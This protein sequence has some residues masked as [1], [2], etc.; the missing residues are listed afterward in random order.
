MIKT[1][2]AKFRRQNRP[3]NTLLPTWAAFLSQKHLILHDLYWEAL[4]L[5]DNFHIDTANANINI[6]PICVYI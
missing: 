3:N 6:G 2:C 1:S 5:I 4:I